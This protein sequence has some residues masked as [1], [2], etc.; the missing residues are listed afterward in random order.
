MLP[1]TATQKGCHILVALYLMI[2]TLPLTA[3]ADYRHNIISAVSDNKNTTF[4]S[5]MS[6]T[7]WVL[8][9]NISSSVKNI[10]KLRAYSRPDSYLTIYF[11]ICSNVI[12]FRWFLVS[13]EQVLGIFVVGDAMLAD[14][15]Y[16]VIRMDGSVINV[17]KQIP[18]PK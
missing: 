15:C 18:R 12:K 8:I 3:F 7:A 10:P 2:K 11:H 13:A 17:Q 4:N 14:C 9:D 5:T 6:A 1:L 16:P